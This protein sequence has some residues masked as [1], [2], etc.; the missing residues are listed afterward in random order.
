MRVASNR[1]EMLSDY[2]GSRHHGGSRD[3]RPD[4][5][6]PR[7]GRLNFSQ[8]YLRNALEALRQGREVETPA[9][10]APGC[11]IDADPAKDR[12]LP[13]LPGGQMFS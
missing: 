7:N 11:Y 8:H 9:T 5:G 4:A 6:L 3:E 13:Q 10:A 12:L 2:S 1:G